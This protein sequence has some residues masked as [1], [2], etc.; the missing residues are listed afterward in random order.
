M[1]LVLLLLLPLA[2]AAAHA[3]PALLPLPAEVDWQ[4]GPPFVVTPR[5]PVVVPP[6]DAEA[7]RVAEAFAALVGNAVEGRPA[8]VEAAPDSAAIHFRIADGHGAEGYALDVAADRVTLTASAPAGLFYG[9]QTLRQLLP[10]RVEYEAAFD[11]PLAVPAVQIA[12]RPRFAWRGMMLDVARHFFE[13]EDVEQVIDLMALH[14]LNRLHLHL[15]DDQGWRFEVPGRP[16]LTRVGGRTEVGGGEGGFYT[17][18]DYARIVRYAA[19]RF[20]TVVPEIDLPGHTNAALAAI[21]ELNCDGV[22]RP[23]YTGTR[24]GFSTV[25]VGKPETWAFVEDVVAALAA[26]TPGPYI[27]LGGDEVERLTEAEYAAFVERAQAVV[28]AHGKTFVGWDDVAEAALAPGAV[29]QVWRPQVPAVVARV[30]EAVAGGA[31]VVLSPSDRIYLDMKYDADTILG[32]T[33][34]GL[35]GVRAVSYTHLTLPT[36]REV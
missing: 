29:V 13:V 14:K 34:A 31:T 20:V 1:R 35:N 11:V 10:P 9:A 36:N 4:D 3:Q 19:E 2:A 28:A 30:A 22:A 17:A 6:D 27:H 15:S 16:A 25:C 7:R 32:L 23:P 26:Q 18:D 21:P 24:V 8:V 12:D 5:T 33:W